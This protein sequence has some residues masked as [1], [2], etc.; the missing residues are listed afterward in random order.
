[1]ETAMKRKLAS[2]PNLGAKKVNDSDALIAALAQV[3]DLFPI[4]E[5]GHPL[6]QAW[7]EAMAFPESVPEYVKQVIAANLTSAKTFK[8]TLFSAL[9]AANTVFVDG[10]EINL[11]IDGSM[12]NKLGLVMLECD[13][14]LT[15]ILP[16]QE[17]EIDEFGTALCERDVKWP[18]SGKVTVTFMT[19]VPLQKSSLL[20]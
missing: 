7:F 17:I 5:P 16:D 11:Q 20:F 1:M 12:I 2:F 13:E 6:E 15:V 4:P 9:A 10:Y 18:L 8:T 14:D 19:K 3:R